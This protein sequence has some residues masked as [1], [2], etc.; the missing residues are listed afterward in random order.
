VLIILL[1]ILH[2][3][4]WIA[5]DGLRQWVSLGRMIDRQEE[6][7]AKF[8][9]RNELLEAEV[10]D[11]KQGLEA[12]EERAR[13]ELGMVG[14]GETFYQFVHEPDHDRATPPSAPT[15]ASP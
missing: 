8:K 4:I 10:R 3:Q 14:E 1:V 15:P 12:V 9:A 13:R 6:K 2:Y 5:P 11:L 7:N